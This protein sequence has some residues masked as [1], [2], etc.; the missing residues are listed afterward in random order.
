MGGSGG[1]KVVIDLGENSFQ[2]PKIAG[3]EKKGGKVSIQQ[4][5]KKKWLKRS[6]RG[7]RVGDLNRRKKFFLRGA[8]LPRGGSSCLRLK[9]IILSRGG[10]CRRL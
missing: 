8:D 5:L 10:R 7:E 4:T 3:G 2:A 9:R 6:L 1:G